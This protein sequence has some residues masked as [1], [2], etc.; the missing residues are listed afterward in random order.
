MKHLELHII[1]SVPVACLNRDDLNSPKTAIFGGVQRAR[2]SSQSW[3]RAIREL[4]KE[5]DTT[6]QKALFKGDRT[7]RMV[8]TMYQRLVERELPE[9]SSLKIAE[10]V[11]DIVEK[12][13]SKVDSEGYKKIKTVMFFSPAEYDS[14]AD[15]ISESEDIKDSIQALENAIANEDTKSCEKVL[16]AMGK[17]LAKGPI[18]KSIKSAQ[19]QDAADIALFGRMV[20][21]HPSLK[22]DG[23][24]MF[25]HILS[26]HKADN[27]IDFFAAVDDLSKDETGAGITSTLEFNSATYYR[28]AALNLDELAN[29]THFGDAVFDDDTIDRTVET[30]KQVVKTFIEATIKAVP[31]ARKTTMNGN[32]LPVYVL[33]V[34][35][36]KGH[37]VQL[38]NAFESPVRRSL[39]GFTTK[40]INRLNREYADLQETWGIESVYAKAVVKSGL[41]DQIQESLGSVETCSLNELLDGMVKHVI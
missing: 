38:V 33:G 20:A 40:S 41:K 13:D 31:S 21:S 2:V 35:R 19:L 28:F 17:T 34:V 23:A 32:T 5:I 9:K 15:L 10:R 18:I 26:T 6:G 12:L 37:P 16:K 25:A 8:Y 36:E 24:S 11:A 22:V 30:R 14:I 4:A 3:K 27:E 39:D 7:R 1:Q 29:D